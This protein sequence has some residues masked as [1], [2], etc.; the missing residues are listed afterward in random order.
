MNKT[1]FLV[2]KQKKLRRAIDDFDKSSILSIDTEYDSFRYFRE[3]LCLIQIRA[4]SA[5]YIFDPLDKIDLSFLGKYFRNQQQVKILHAADN[6]IRLLKR[7]YGFVFENIFDTHRAAHLLGFQQLSLEKMINQFLQV[8]L[9]KN[10]KMQRSRWDNRPL[11]EEQLQYAAQDV[12]YL[13]ALYQEQLGELRKRGL[14]EAAL[15]AFAKIAAVNWQEK[16][17][18]K[19]GHTKIAGYHFLNQQQKETLQKLYI[20]RFQRAKDENRAIFMFLPDKILS[21]LVQNGDN[22]RDILPLEKAK[23]YSDELARIINGNRF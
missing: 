21:D 3:K 11:T 8:D 20:W 14:E 5:T 13:P 10:K 4:R 2:D 18:D 19:R 6:D 9:K 12:I 1:W 7:D 15:D 22:W 17:I 16:T 23:L